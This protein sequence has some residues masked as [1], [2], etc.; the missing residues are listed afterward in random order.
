METLWK[1]IVFSFR[2][3]RRR[4]GLTLVIL[5]SL[6]LGIGVN[7]TIFTFVNAILLQPLPGI[8]Q[9]NQ[10]VEVYTSYASGLKFGSVSYLD[11]KDLRDRN[12]VFSGLMA[13]RLTLLNL[14]NE[15]GNEIVPA[16][17]VSGNY[18]SVLGVEPARGRFF[19]PEEDQ[20]PNTDAV[21]VISYTLWQNRFAGDPNLVGKTITINARSF[22]VVGVAPERFGGSN[23]GLAPDVWVP[24]M[25]QSVAVPGDREVVLR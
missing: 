14:N 1:D 20:N 16:A 25:M 5:L 19:L 3:M 4:P 6:G 17:I 18:F 12:Q 11:Y 8:A 13:Q 21:A 7:L 23:V 15:G 10:L 2:L 24:L 9:Q 22:T